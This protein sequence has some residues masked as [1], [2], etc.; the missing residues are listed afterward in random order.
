MNKEID[1]VNKENYVLK[2]LNE[3][4]GVRKYG[5]W[6]GKSTRTRQQVWADRESELKTGQQRLSSLNNR[7]ENHV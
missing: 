6:N 2:E 3:N 7:E 4:P 1:N 5:N